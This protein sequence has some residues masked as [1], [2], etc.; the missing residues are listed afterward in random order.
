[1]QPKRLGVDGHWTRGIIMTV[2]EPT[3]LVR[4]QAK[5]RH[6]VR[7]SDPTTTIRGRVVLRVS[8]TPCGCG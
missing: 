5:D 3:I 1:M 2:Y 4:T 6:V 8:K 7:R